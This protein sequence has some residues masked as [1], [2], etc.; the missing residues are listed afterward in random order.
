MVIC[1]RHENVILVLLWMTDCFQV[2]YSTAWEEKGCIQ[3]SE[4]RQM[5]NRLSTKVTIITPLN[6]VKSIYI[7]S[8]FPEYTY[9]VFTRLSFPQ[10]TQ[11]TSERD[12]IN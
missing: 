9:L 1:H 3:S 4:N 11:P 6:S 5:E 10:A 8:T 12:K 2:T 7:F